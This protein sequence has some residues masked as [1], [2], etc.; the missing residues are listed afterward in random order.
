VKFTENFLTHTPVGE[1][2]P[3]GS[4]YDK[5]QMSI[6]YF[7]CLRGNGRILWMEGELI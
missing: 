6:K 5:I 7:I 1:K 3:T 2:V 4:V